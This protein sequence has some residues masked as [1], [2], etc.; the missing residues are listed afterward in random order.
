MTI[1]G[2][3]AFLILLALSALHAAWAF[4]STFPAATEADLARMVAGFR[5]RDRMPPAAAAAGVALA[6]LGAG[7]FALDLGGMIALPL[8]GW[9][10]TTG[11]LA[12]ALVFL[13]RGYL[14][15]TDAWR[16]LTPEQPFARLDTRFYSP[17]CL[18][19]GGAFLLLVLE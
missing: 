15:F 6:L 4:G 16:R 2:L 19:L 5:G 11:G 1:I 17:L 3:L 7:L 8:P 18:L 10:A 13:T 9:L 12:L 14:G